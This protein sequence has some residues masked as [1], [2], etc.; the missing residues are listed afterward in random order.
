MAEK[1]CQI[2]ICIRDENAPLVYLINEKDITKDMETRMNEEMG[3]Y[4]EW[5]I[6][7][8]ACEEEWGL[9]RV[10]SICNIKTLGIRMNVRGKCLLERIITRT[11]YYRV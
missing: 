9:R 6:P 5:C 11:Y 7:A 2:I 10:S 8:K 4:P 1:Y 3:G